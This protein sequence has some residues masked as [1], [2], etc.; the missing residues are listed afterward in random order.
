MESVK[1]NQPITYDELKLLNPSLQFLYLE[2]LIK[3]YKARRKDLL[4][5]LRISPPTWQRITQ[6]LPNKLAFNGKPEHPSEEWLR[7]INGEAEDVTPD[8]QPAPGQADAEPEVEVRPI[9]TVL[10]AKP[11]VLPRQFSFTLDGTVSDLAALLSVF[12]EENAVYS[13]DL[14]IRKA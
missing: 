11:D 9:S 10:I 1:L 2:H 8:D 13:F 14:T 5:M 4:E 12:T 7:F 3:D 6:G